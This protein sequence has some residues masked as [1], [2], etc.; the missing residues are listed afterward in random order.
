MMRINIVSCD[1]FLSL[2]FKNLLT[3]DGSENLEF[4]MTEHPELNSDCLIY[5]KIYSEFLNIKDINKFTNYDTVLIDLIN[6]I[7]QFSGNELIIPVP[8]IELNSDE[9][10][11]SKIIND[12]KMKSIGVA[13]VKLDLDTPTEVIETAF[14]YNN[15]RVAIV[16]VDQMKLI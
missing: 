8:K 7:H 16:T 10:V 6:L 1:E 12:I 14:Y 2:K 3:K 5:S 13:K 11:R 15:K 9:L 4:S